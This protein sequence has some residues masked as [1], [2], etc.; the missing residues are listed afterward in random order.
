MPLTPAERQKRY[1]QKH[2]AKVLAA[3]KAYN[4]AHPETKRASNRRYRLKNAEKIRSY[5]KA[6]RKANAQK[7]SEENRA[8][9]LAHPEEK[10]EYSRVYKNRHREKVREAGRLYAATHAKENGLRS[11]KHRQEHPDLYKAKKKRRRALELNAPVADLTHMQWLAIQETQDHRCA[12][13]G[14][15]CK[16]HLTQDHITPLSKGGSHTLHNVIAACQSCN[17]RKQVG[18]PLKPVQPLLL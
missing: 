15:R 3:I 17:S 12:Y 8:Y 13:C 18:P 16:G 6:Y 4:L 9:R 14:K 1:R 10:R 2:K 11:R 5:R 7:L